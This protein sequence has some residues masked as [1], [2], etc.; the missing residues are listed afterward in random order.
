[1]GLTWSIRDVCKY[2]NLPMATA[3]SISTPIGNGAQLLAFASIYSQTAKLLQKLETL[4]D[5]LLLE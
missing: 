4:K 3:T 1:M 5:Q 2:A